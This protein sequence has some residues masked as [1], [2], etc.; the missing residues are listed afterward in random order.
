MIM[1]SYIRI[2]F[3]GEVMFVLL[4]FIIH[5][6]IIYTFIIHTFSFPKK[7]RAEFKAGGVC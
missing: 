6:F 7:L 2:V 5:T 1:A 4:K 3:E